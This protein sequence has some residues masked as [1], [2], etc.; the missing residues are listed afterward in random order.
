MLDIL[1]KQMELQEV[2]NQ[3]GLEKK[4]STSEIILN[5]LISI[6]STR[7]SG[8]HTCE[9]KDFILNI[10]SSFLNT[11][12]NG[13]T[14]VDS[15]QC[16]F[17]ELCSIWFQLALQLLEFFCPSHEV[18][19]T[20]KSLDPKS[21][22]IQPLDVKKMDSLSNNLKESSERENKESCSEEMK[23]G[24]NVKKNVIQEEDDDLSD[25]ER[26]ADKENENTTDYADFDKLPTSLKLL[27]LLLK[28]LESHKNSDVIYHIVYMIKKLCLHAEV[29]SKAAKDHLDYLSYAQD[30]LLI[31]NF[32]HLLQNEFSQISEL[33]VPLLLHSLLLPYGKEKFWHLIRN[34]FNS[35]K[36]FERFTAVERV[37][38]I[39]HFLD[40]NFIKN[41]LSLQNSLANCFA[42]LVQCLDDIEATVSQRTL[43]NLESIRTNSLKLMISCLELQFDTMILDRPIILQTIFQLYNHLSERRFLT[44]DFFSQSI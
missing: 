24:Y 15:T 9:Y 36:W 1:I 23:D 13:N 8:E 27:H 34:E 6:L 4:D 22:E 28:S 44:W 5:L 43:L 11:I 12:S 40:I 38:T 21:V 16:C 42:Y 37:T 20:E 17:C 26:K 31:I 41:A 29:L 14:Q 18:P 35:T 25:N 39:A 33:A 19:M 2:T 32:Y 10:N 7:W 3:K 30:K